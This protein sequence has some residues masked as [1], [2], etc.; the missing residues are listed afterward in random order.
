MGAFDPKKALWSHLP[1]ICE[2]Y[3][4]G[5]WLHTYQIIRQMKR[6]AVVSEAILKNI[7]SIFCQYSATKLI[8]DYLVIC[9]TLYYDIILPIVQY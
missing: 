1:V 5:I 9:S 8:S 6:G 3:L 4:C 2:S 7:L